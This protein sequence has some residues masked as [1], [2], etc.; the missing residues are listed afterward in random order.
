MFTTG[1][2]AQCPALNEPPGLVRASLLISAR[3]IKFHFVLT[4]KTL[5][6]NNKLN[7]ILRWHCHFIIILTAW[8][9]N[10][11]SLASRF[12]SI[13]EY[14]FSQQAI[15]IKLY[16][17]A[18]SKLNLVIQLHMS[19]S[20]QWQIQT[21]RQGGGGHPDPEIMGGGGGGGVSKNIFS[22]LI[23]GQKIRGGAGPGPLPW[24]CH[25]LVWF[26]S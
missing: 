4:E 1:Q 17:N 10:I 20:L 13:Q 11:L 12:P 25:C 26:L 21:F 8:R 24:I 14:I 9:E 3:S 19:Y 2:F 6:R 5:N 23:L 15:N 16:C 22:G 7:L 18:I